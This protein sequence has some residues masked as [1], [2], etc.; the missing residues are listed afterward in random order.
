MTKPKY[1]Q[2]LALTTM[3][4]VKRNLAVTALFIFFAAVS[5]VEALIKTI[6]GGESMIFTGTATGETQEIRTPVFDGFESFTISFW[7]KSVSPGSFMAV[8]RKST[9]S[10]K[11]FKYLV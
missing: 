3:C 10:N 1:R 9:T 2:H 7:Y 5:Q 6:G 4:R 8:C 11:T